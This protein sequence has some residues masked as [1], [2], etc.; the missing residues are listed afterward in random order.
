MM[1]PEHS[2]V[3]AASAQECFDAICAFETYPSWQRAVKSV[4][5]RDDGAVAYEVDAKVRTIRY[6]LRYHYDEPRRVWWDYVEGD[7]DHV[8]GEFRF[9]DLGDG[10]TRATY[11]LDIEPGVFVPGPVKRILRDQVMKAAVT[12]LKRHLEP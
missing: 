7:A 8:T 1:G 10:T 6:V 9:D 2:E 4:T 3:I 5:V 11:A 12:D